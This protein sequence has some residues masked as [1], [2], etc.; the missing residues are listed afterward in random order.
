[1]LTEKH[2]A[3]VRAALRFLDEEMRPSGTDAI[4]HYHD[5]LGRAMDVEV[6]DINEAREFFGSVDLSYVL[7]DS[8][9]VSIESKRLFPASSFDE[10]NFQ[11]D[12]SLLAAVLVPA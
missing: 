9:G 6:N 4:V 10:L 12:L 5:D 3:V 8:T 2:L 11:S 1:M 7:V